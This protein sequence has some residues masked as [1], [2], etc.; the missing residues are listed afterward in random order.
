LACHVALILEH[1]KVTHILVEQTPTYLEH[2]G[3]LSIAL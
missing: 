1:K 3:I 2:S